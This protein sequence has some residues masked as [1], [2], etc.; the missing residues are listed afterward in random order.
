MVVSNIGT[1]MQRVAQDWLVLQLTAGSAVA[2]GITTGL[3]F[4]PMLASPLGGLLADRL[5]KVKILKVTQVALAA[6]ALTQGILTL[7]GAIQVWNVYLL[8]FLLGVVNA[9]DTPARQSVVGEL[10]PVEDLP[11][12][13]GLNSVSFQT[14][15]IVGPGVAGLLIML[16]GIGWVF[17]L[18]ALTFLG[19]LLMLMRMRGLTPPRRRAKDSGGLRAGLAYVRGRPDLQLIMAVAFF[20]G[21]FGLNFQMTMALMSTEVYGKGAGEFGLLGSI[22]AIGSLAGALLA[23]RRG[24]VSHRFVVAAAVLFGAVEIAASTMPTYALF[25]IFLTLAG[26]TALTLMTAINSYM[27]TTVDPGMR[28]RVMSLYLLVF[29][30]GTP[31][32]APLVGWVGEHLG[33][34]WTI[35]G[36]GLATALGAIAV[37]AVFAARSGL[38]MRPVRWRARSAAAGSLA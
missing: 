20:T 1:W 13:V 36:G 21:T 28:G 11:N 18:N 27:Q 15:R 4:L 35:A 17:V 6:L 14:A 12:A 5:P 37:T 24:Q 16:V 22:L 30:G 2:L 8:A 3:Q 26:F 33:P 38:E 10:V 34:R 29:M 19:P 7:S 9:L 23:A 25:A 31:F 32:G